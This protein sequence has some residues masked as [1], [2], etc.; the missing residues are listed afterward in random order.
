[1][2]NLL[3]IIFS[4][5]CFVAVAGAEDTKQLLGKVDRLIKEKKFNA[6]FSI[7]EKADRD[8]NDPEITLKKVDIAL[9]FFV[10]SF[11]Y[12]MFAFKDLETN[13]NI[14]DVRGKE[15]KYQ[16]YLLNVEEVLGKLMKRYPDN[17]KLRR[18]LGEYYFEVF[19][20]YGDN[21]DKPKDEIM[22]LGKKHLLDARKH[23]V[24]DS[25]SLFKLGTFYL[26]EKQYDEAISYLSESVKLNKTYPTSNYNLAYAYLYKDK[27]KEAIKY[28]QEALALYTEKALKGDAARLIA[29]TYG[30]LRDD[31]NS[32]KYF[33]IADEIQPRNYYTVKPL[34]SLH[35]KS[36]N[37][38]AANEAAE[39]LFSLDPKNPTVSNDVLE[40]YLSVGYNKELHDFFTRM[41]KR[42]QDNDEETGN[43]LFHKAKLY[44]IENHKK[45]AKQVIIEA[46]RR[47]SKCLKSDH[48]VFKAIDQMLKNAE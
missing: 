46:R 3:L 28:A 43:V 34:L 18:M 42:Y 27:R 26:E 21:W 4:I 48:D 7:L 39:T 9:D 29:V 20:K 10:M 40:A 25:K 6:A 24:A 14:E 15:G 35:L 8:C 45:E 31:A 32:L 1:V 23:N 44:L 22:K 11:H 33:K 16:M 19:S 38:I 12:Q 13:E 37:M 17:W 41:E 36:K 5:F 30:E 47:F 2:K